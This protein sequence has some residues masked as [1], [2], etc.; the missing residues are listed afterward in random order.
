MKA[1]RDCFDPAM[2]SMAARTSPESVIEVFSFILL[3][4][5]PFSFRI[6]IWGTLTRSG[7]L[8]PKNGLNGP[9]APAQTPH[10]FQMSESNRLM[11]SCDFFVSASFPDA[12]RSE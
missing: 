7:P 3:S 8:K 11:A 4:Y 6:D 10:A 12:A 5:Y 1:E 2:R 9:L